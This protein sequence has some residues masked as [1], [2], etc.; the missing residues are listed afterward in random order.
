MKQ[1][2]LL[3]AL[4]G[5]STHAASEQV[6]LLATA[7]LNDTTMAQSIFL[8]EPAITDLQGCREAL[9]QGQRH[10][11][12]LQYHHVLRRD[13]MQ[14]FTVQ[15]QYRC[16]TSRQAIE[17]WFDRARYSHP[18][19]IRVDD[20]SRLDVRPMQSMAACMGIYRALAPDEQARSH[21]AKGNQR[22]R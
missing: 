14:G 3:L 11:D 19:L 20:Q 2:L 13:R 16:V 15:M 10:G 5:L 4:V 18:Y 12:W 8:S 6:Y 17:P 1:G 22:L 9:R 21:C 7:G